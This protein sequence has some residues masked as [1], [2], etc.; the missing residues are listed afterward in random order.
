[1]IGIAIF[2]HHLWDIDLIIRRTLVYTIL[3]V[4]LAL[5]YFGTVVLLQELFTTAIGHQTPA[6]IVL[7]TLAIA[8]LFTPFRRRLQTF[9]DRRFYRRKYNT[10]RVLAEFS[11]ILREKVEL[12]RRTEAI[13]GVVVET[14]Q[15]E[16]VSL[17]LREVDGHPGE[18]PSPDG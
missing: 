12:D 13:L 15:P 14:M 16:N 9:I 6:A 5:V 8:A 2:R 11:L 1:V 3:T 7:S 17:W 10:E 18:R 4:I